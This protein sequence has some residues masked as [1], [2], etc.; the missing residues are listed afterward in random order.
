[1]TGLCSLYTGLPWDIVIAFL[2]KY[3]FC[4]DDIDEIY[5]NA[6]TFS[7]IMLKNGQTYFNNL[8]MFTPQHFLSIFDH[9]ST[10][11]KALSLFFVWDHCRGYSSRQNGRF[12]SRFL[13]V[14]FTS[15]TRQSLKFA[16]WSCT[17]VITTTP[18]RHSPWRSL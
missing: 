8:V 14:L 11:M 16:E 4:D 18:R 2:L 5:K 9:S 7:C 3:Q 12:S 15:G 10:C 1:M 6:L 17:T 13:H